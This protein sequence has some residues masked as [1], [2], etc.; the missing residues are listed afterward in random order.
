MHT[1]IHTSRYKYLIHVQKY[2]YSPMHICMDAP[3]NLYIHTYHYT[4]V[5]RY[6]FIPSFCNKVLDMAT[7]SEHD[8]DAVAST[9]GVC[10]LYNGEAMHMRVVCGVGHV[11]S[12]TALLACVTA[13]ALLLLLIP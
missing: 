1:F 9:V 11:V 10:L 13:H 2:T 5:R 8:Q 6:A 12:C 7:S 3:A 4:Y